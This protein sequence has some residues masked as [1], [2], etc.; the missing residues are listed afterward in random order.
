MESCPW[1]HWQPASLEFCESRLCGWIVEP[2]NTWSNIGFILVGFWVLWNVRK[3]ARVDLA[4][5]GLTAVLVGIG[6]TLFHMTATRFGEILDLSAMYLISAMFVVYAAKRHWIMSTAMFVGIYALLAGLAVAAMIAS[7]SNGIHVFASHVAVAVILEFSA[8]KRS[9]SRHDYRN[10][11]WMTVTFALAFTSWSLDV[12][13]RVCIP[14][15]HIFGGHAFWHLANAASLFFY[16]RH[17]RQM[18]KQ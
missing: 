18:P 9:A 17:Q 1:S 6:S 14:D 7:G 12:S 4:L 10:L 8:F 16:F 13:R 5:I 2:A 3:L 11:K 15:N